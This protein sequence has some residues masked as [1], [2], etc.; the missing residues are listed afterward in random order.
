MAGP[1]SVLRGNNVRQTGL[2]SPGAEQ[3]GLGGARA[4]SEPD[5]RGLGRLWI[6]LVSYARKGRGRQEAELAFGR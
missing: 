6:R 2:L 4:V 3:D 1:G 5:A